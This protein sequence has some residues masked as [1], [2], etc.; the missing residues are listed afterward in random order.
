MMDYNRI[1]Q[2]L[3]NEHK[4]IEWEINANYADRFIAWFDFLELVGTEREVAFIA[5]L[6]LAKRGGED[7]R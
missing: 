1:I 4:M 7:D 6:E 3:I 2:D 5:A